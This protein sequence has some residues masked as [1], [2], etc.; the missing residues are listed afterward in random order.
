MSGAADG[1][2]GEKLGRYTDFGPKTAGFVSLNNINN[3]SGGNSCTTLR[4]ALNT[5]PTLR[6]QLNV[7]Q[8]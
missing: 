5:N 7:K 2:A 8:L 3:S 6:P 4:A 1:G